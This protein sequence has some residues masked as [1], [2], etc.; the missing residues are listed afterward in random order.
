MQGL[1]YAHRVLAPVIPFWHT[2]VM[3]NLANIR[4]MRGLNQSQLA[5][6]VGANQSTISKIEDGKAN[7]TLSM[8]NRIA[9]ALRVHP[10]ML[11][12]TGSMQQRAL[13]AIESIDDPARKE[14]AVIVLESMVGQQ[15]PKQPPK[16]DQAD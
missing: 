9:K 8:I 11:F 15:S 10:S 6:L 12:T 2:L 3:D 16:P 5:K 7:P 4:E 14:A 1:N 13:N